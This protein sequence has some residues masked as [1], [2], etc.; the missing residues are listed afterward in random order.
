MRIIVTGAGGFVGS[1]LVARLADH[2][3]VALDQDA[4]GIPDLPH[5]TGLAGDLCDPA[6]LEAAMHG[7]CDAVVHLATVPGGAAEQQP[8]LARRVNVDASMALA[9]AAAGAGEQPRFVF[10]SSIA[11]FGAPL[12]ASV[13]DSTPVSPTLRYGAHKAMMELWISTL[14][15][16]GAI[17]GLSLRLPG[18]VARPRGPSGMKSAF[19]SDVFHAMVSGESCTL[20]VSA[21]ATSWLISVECAAANLV[22]ALR[23]DL[24]KAPPSRALTL[25]ALRVSM[26]DLLSE[27]ARQT[28]VSTAAVSY[29]P[30]SDIEATFGALPPLRTDA[31][32]ALGF[33]NDG[34]LT[35]LV[36]RVLELLA[37]SGSRPRDFL[38]RSPE[39]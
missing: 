31:A 18:V 28:S 8:G 17:D 2:D 6:V 9:D 3:V 16:R 19:L 37:R 15:R 35:G 24:T 5:V 1:R 25:P 13:D 26:S 29:R 23:A 10:A 11:V 14:T 32:N 12:P 38:F 36:A 34:D 22:H 39:R 4:G 21:G 27:I 20:P 33:D 30:D 7:G